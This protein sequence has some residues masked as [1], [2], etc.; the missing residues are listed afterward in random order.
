MIAPI[1]EFV[2]VENVVPESKLSDRFS[3]DFPGPR[4]LACN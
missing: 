2:V 4:L 1:P 3:L